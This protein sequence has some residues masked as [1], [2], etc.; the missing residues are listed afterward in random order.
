[1]LR[2][3]QYRGV[4]V[5]GVQTLSIIIGDSSSFDSKYDSFFNIST[6]SLLAPECYLD[7]QLA[8]I[9]Y[10]HW[11][12]ILLKPSVFDIDLC[13]CSYLSDNT[14]GINSPRLFIII[15]L[16]N[17]DKVEANSLDG[18]VFCTSLDMRVFIEGQAEVVLYWRILLV[19]HLYNTVRKEVDLVLLQL[20][21]I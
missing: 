5:T 12:L 4:I 15:D 10:G 21:V 3:Y 8:L 6:C 9:Y 20:L 18:V 13:D 2:L 1:M 19:C 16:I 7:L 11:P 17:G 14:N